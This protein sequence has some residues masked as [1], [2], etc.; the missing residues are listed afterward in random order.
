VVL[1]LEDELDGI[2]RRSADT[3]GSERE[4]SVGATNNDLDGV[5]G[6]RD[7]GG[8]RRVGVRRIGRR[9][10]VGTKGDGVGHE[11]WRR[12]RG[13]GGASVVS[14]PSGCGRVLGSTLEH[15]TN[16]ESG[17]LEVG[18]RVGAS[19][20][21]TVD[22]MDHTSSTMGIRSVGRLVTEHPDRLSIIY[23]D[24]ERG[25]VGHSDV[26]THWL[27]TRVKPTRFGT[28]RAGE[29]RL[30]HS[31]VL[32]V[33]VV[34]DLVT[35]DCGNRLWRKSKSTIHTTNLDIDDLGR[36]GRSED[37]TDERNEHGWQVRVCVG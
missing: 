17:L 34:D 12:G 16:V 31:V 30:G 23:V 7:R 22:G 11:R 5:S 8:S 28:T 3:V 4:I 19:V 24:S 18:E 1:N 13:D 36:N 6:R 35:G 26:G 10:Y 15:G 25:P 32:G 21:T 27:E 2:T 20:S 37:K 9:P 14:G 33:K 29:R